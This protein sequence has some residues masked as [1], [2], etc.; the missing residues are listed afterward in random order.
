M[1]QTIRIF[2]GLKRLSLFFLEPLLNNSEGPRLSLTDLSEEGCWNCQFI[3][4]E[5][6]MF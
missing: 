4:R 5:W 1:R 6:P 3:Y 2:N